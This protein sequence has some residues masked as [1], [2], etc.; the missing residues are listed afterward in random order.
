ML[1]RKGGFTENN[2]KVKGL[3]VEPFLQLLCLALYSDSSSVIFYGE[4]Q[5]ISQ[6]DGIPF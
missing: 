5:F 2:L 6:R 1:K 3:I 4:S